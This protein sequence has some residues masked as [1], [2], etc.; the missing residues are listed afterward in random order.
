MENT[1]IKEE[2]GNKNRLKKIKS[3]FFIPIIFEHIEKVKLFKIIKINRN[4]Q[5][6]LDINLD[7]YKEYSVIHSTIEL[8]IRPVPHSIGKFINIK[9]DEENYFHIY[10]NDNKEEI[11]RTE[12]KNG[13]NISKINWLSSSIIW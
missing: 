2:E 6:K 11:K 12:L 3:E 10:F 9:K 4:I 7:T 13:D 5:Q 8:E 1:T